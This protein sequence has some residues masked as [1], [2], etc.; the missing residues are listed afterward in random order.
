MLQIGNE[1][2][3]EST[4]SEI[5]EYYDNKNF[6]SND[7][8]GISKGATKEDELFDYVNIP[9]YYKKKKIGIG[10]KMILR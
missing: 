3:I 1:P 2:T 5:K 9:S 7:V 6:D 8:Y 10:I 4:T